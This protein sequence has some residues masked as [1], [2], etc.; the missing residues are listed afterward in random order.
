MGCGLCA[1]VCP[2][3]MPDCFNEGLSFRKAIYLPV[4]HAIP[5]SYVIDLA[6]CNRCGACE[7]ICPT[8]AIRL[9]QSN[10]KA[11]NILVVDDELSI[12]DSLKEWLEEADFS[13]DMAA[14]GAD[15]LEKLSQKTYQLML[16]DIKMPQMSGV[17]LLKKVKQDHPDL[18]VVMMTAYA[19]VETAVAAM[20][21]G[22]LDYL[23]KPFDPDILIPMVIGIF[24]D[25][26]ATKN[27]ELAIDTIIFSTG[28]SFYD[29]ADEKNIFGYG[30][31]PNVITNIEFERMLSL[32]GPSRGSLFRLD[33]DKKGQPVKKIAWIQCVGS[34]D[35]QKNTDFC[36]GICCMVAIKEAVLA[37]KI[38][39]GAIDTTIFYMDMRTFGKSFQR[40]YDSAL[41]EHGVRF[42][43]CKIHSLSPDQKT[44]NLIIRYIATT[45]ELKKE[46][47]DM[48][49][50][51]VGQRPGYKTDQLAKICDLPLNPWGFFRTRP[52]SFTLTEKEGIFAGG[53]VTGLKDISQS[54]IQASAAAQNAGCIICTK[55]RK[56]LEESLEN[57]EIY[58]DVS[59]E[60]ARLLMVICTCN[61]RLTRCIAPNRITEKFMEDPGIGHIHF[62]DT[63]C[64]NQGWRELE[65]V[66]L[67]YQPNRL[68][69]GACHP[70]LFVRKIREIAKKSA[71]NPAYID[72]I[73]I[74]TGV[75]HENQDLQTEL[76]TTGRC[77]TGIL[78]SGA[79]ALKQAQYLPLSKTPVF[80][81]A[82]VMG[83]GIAG[84]TAALGIADQGYEVV[85]VEKTGQL[86]GN[87]NWLNHTIDGLSCKT[88]L[89]E[90]IARLQK[91]PL[92]RIFLNSQII[93]TTG[94]APRFSSIIENA[95]GRPV[96]YEHGAT[97]LA[98]G[99]NEAK[100]QSHNYG[101]Q[102]SVITQ[103]ELEIRLAESSID[104]KQLNSI[105]MILCV[106]SRQEPR[107]YCSRVCCPAALKQALFIKAQNPETNIYFLYRDMMA[108][109]FTETFFTQAREEN[110][111]FISYGPDTL[112]QIED[113]DGKMVVHALEP[114]LDSPIQ[115]TADMV[116]LGTGITPE[117]P[118]SLASMLGIMPDTDGFF[119]EADPKWRPVDAMKEGIFACGIVH[120]PGSIAESITTAQAAAQ[121]ALNIISRP[122][123]ASARITAT[124]RHSLCSLCQ[125]CITTCPYGARMLNPDE[126]KVLVNEVMCQGCGSCAAICP[127]NASVLQGY[128]GQQMLGAIDAVFGDPLN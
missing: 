23:V 1:E 39:N 121:R 15:A 75:F 45:G 20:K 98:T 63:I 76:D 66:V 24:Q 115:I 32:T 5:N 65:K 59:R 55:G 13:V 81:K 47:F 72:F 11:F 17:E 114:I 103:K 70:Y 89:E 94:Y 68:L 104:M 37:K 127:N 64:T 110:I 26:E 71:L 117:F 116:V 21:I 123:L 74:M 29:P 50:L 91:Q 41:N 83:G 18:C 57:K 49:V 51:S 96:T 38:S 111:L 80:A 112:P 102:E 85:L 88:L 86:G 92:I 62:T 109:G 93:N 73:D 22:A 36:S 118:D 61:K 77:I 16:T 78:S 122:F 95:E 7:E 67:D 56:K 120:S 54:I 126:T 6:G 14:S 84:M 82:L 2:R 106:D 12:R 28:T 34:R 3:E 42:E 35:I 27:L 43:R 46:L 60:P 8:D 113:I 97:I 30:I 124:V 69:V 105:V 52:F 107:N 4:P 40:Y 19:T 44:N 53:S 99:G 58:R 119:Q 90:T 125:K 9:S 25:I 79:E 10:R 31:Y 100:T 108:C 48:A 128:S 87:L 33:K 101:K